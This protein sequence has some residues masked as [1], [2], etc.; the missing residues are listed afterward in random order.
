MT[1]AVG[2]DK[3]IVA[4]ALAGLGVA[5]G[6]WMGMHSRMSSL[7]PVADAL[8]AQGH[9]ATALGCNAVIDGVLQAVG[10]DGLLMVP[11]F[12][13]CFVGRDCAPW[14]K[15]TSSSGTGK[16]TEALLRRPDAVRSNHP[17]HSVACIGRDAAKATADHEN[18]TAFGVDSPY[19]RLAEAGGW[20]LYLGTAG[21]TLSL[22][23]V[24]EVLSG[25]PYVEAFCWEHAGWKPAARV[26]N[27]D[28]S[29]EI[30]AQRQAPG[31]SKNFVVFD[32]EAEKEGLLR[33]GK[34]YD[35]PLVLFRAADAIDLALDRIARDPTV[36]LCEPGACKTCDCRRRVL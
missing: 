2:I 22:L 13:Y 30:V 25:A 35:A 9:E 29:V 19:H 21:A 28:G 23:H 5:R 16:L 36:F 11:T 32:V 4:K 6:D 10:P 24:A 31:C 3:N 8:R 18:R 33:H 26:E 1:Q 27:A 12:S 7:G 17:T 34:L 14:N 15:R 20:M